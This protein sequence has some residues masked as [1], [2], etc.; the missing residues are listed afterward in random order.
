MM[1]KLNFCILKTISYGT[2][3]IK[4]QIERLVEDHKAMTILE[5]PHSYLPCEEI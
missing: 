4:T 5:S 1:V 2:K 3:I